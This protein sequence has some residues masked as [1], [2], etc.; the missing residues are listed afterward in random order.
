MQA[1][2]LYTASYIHYIEILIDET[3]E[4]ENLLLGG[5]HCFSHLYSYTVSRNSGGKGVEG[6]L[7]GGRL[8]YNIVFKKVKKYKKLS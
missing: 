2:F 7:K 5:E 4:Q 1:T 8:Y 3:N 6:R